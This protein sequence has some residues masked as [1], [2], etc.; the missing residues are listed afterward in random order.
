MTTLSAERWQQLQRLLD[1]LL[2]LPV[3]EQRSRLA[4]H[5]DIDAAMRAE[6]ERLLGA[7]ENVGNFLSQPAAELAAPLV[8]A[9]GSRTSGRAH[10]QR[11]G[12]YRIIKEIGRG[13]MG[14]VYLAERADDQFRHRAAIKLLPYE[15]RSE[16]SLRRFLEE[17]QIL[18]TMEH[19][20]IAR[21]LD[22]GM[23]ED[24]LPYFVMEYIDGV[25]I[26]SYCDGR[27]LP[28]DERLRLFCTVC[29][30]VQYA[31]G[32]LVVHRDI[33][34]SNIL[35][36]PNAEVR[37][38][39]FGIAK[40]LS[41][42]AS[43]TTTTGVRIMTPEYASPEQVRGE[44]P[45]T[46]SDVYSLGVLLYRLL[47]GRRPY[48]ITGHSQVEFER[49]ILQEEPRPPSAVTRERDTIPSAADVAAAR[50]T[51]PDRLHR[52]LTGD[53]DVI[54][55]RSLQKEVSRRYASVEQL[56]RDVRRYLEGRPVVARKDSTGYRFSKF[57]RRNRAVVA[58]VAV[59]V[60]AL[61]VGTV[62]AVWQARRAIAQARIASAERDRA[63]REEA[64]ARE[65]AKFLFE[66][67]Q[68]AN[69]VESGGA[70]LTA[71][72][73][74]D[75]GA[76]RVEHELTTPSD[77]RAG[78]RHEIGMAYYGLAHPREAVQQ[79]ERALADRVLLHG[80]HHPDVALTLTDLGEAL[81][82]DGK[83]DSAEKALRP[84]VAM[85]REFFGNRDPRTA[86]ALNNL[87]LVLQTR[88]RYAE[89]RPLHEE[90]LAVRL[91]LRDSAGA[92]IS[93]VNLGWLQQAAG[94][95]L[96]SAEA[97]LRSA[98][99]IRRRIYRAGDPR[100]AS[101][102]SGL[103]EMLLQEGKYDE[104]EPLLREALATSQ[105]L[106]GPRSGKASEELQALGDVMMHKGQY[107]TA[108]SLYRGAIAIARENFGDQDVRTALVMN[109]YAGSLSERGRFREA[110]GW[111]EAALRAYKAHYGP[112]H[113]FTG[114]VLGNVANAHHLLGDAHTAETLYREAIR[115]MRAKWGDDNTS[116]VNA[117]VSHGLVLVS[118]GRHREAEAELRPALERSIHGY[119]PGH[120]RIALAENA[121]G[122]ALSAQRKFDEADTLLLDGLRGLAAKR[123][124]NSLDT[125]LARMRV[126]AHYQRWRRPELAVRYRSE[127]P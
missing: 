89:A 14:A 2:D 8:R 26:D 109:N 29:D 34:P 84:A 86:T 59:A 12:P 103:A 48:H 75:R 32:K 18:A 94:G 96:D 125:R 69:P 1:E 126:V 93:L 67:F 88:A 61:L 63:Q 80:R 123:G 76:E 83:A 85:N 20:A 17:R 21:L 113:P 64:K 114:I 28:I 22:G 121:L 82:S 25:P 122:S 10:G 116:T 39:D 6:V 92:S 35:V 45:T 105:K 118:L 49:A 43:T 11:I 120:W 13:G 107:G 97:L 41:G 31:H 50:R 37:L 36:T 33:K 110:L 3:E 62:T 90:A 30:A 58:A 9:I 56:S 112:E 66:I 5:A 119:P 54:V 77:I 87:G 42:D 53:L 4:T 73:L 68:S 95:R 102:V 108:D 98:V 78:V 16:M 38:L 127:I 23:T 81:W 19:P 47:T 40:L 72:D 115:I 46:A 51:T 100:T 111:Y 91:S 106:F 60:F 70:L 74:L 55:L 99:E 71:R 117:T 79:L 27:R 52:A 101:A 7:G 124:I 44:S 104:A 24:G 15:A 57:V 65:T